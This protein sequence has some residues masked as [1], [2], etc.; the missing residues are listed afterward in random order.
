[1]QLL[2][3]CTEDGLK[4]RAGLP[5]MLIGMEQNWPAYSVH[6][7]GARSVGRLRMAT[8]CF[9]ARGWVQAV[10]LTPSPLPI[11]GEGRSLVA[12][13]HAWLQRPGGLLAATKP[14]QPQAGAREVPRP[15]ALHKQGSAPP[16]GAA[17]ARAPRRQGDGLSLQL[18]PQCST[19][20]RASLQP[21][22]KCSTNDRPSPRLGRGEGVRATRC[23]QTPKPGASRCSQP[24]A[25]QHNAC[26][27][28]DYRCR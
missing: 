28:V 18:R 13:S 4:S 16:A 6:G 25:A 22:P 8:L 2:P 24:R 23:S 7:H 3:I 14:S 15:P 21:R 27:G 19:K 11:L 20:D 5:T 9:P 12:A 1:M 17:A 10:A 26:A